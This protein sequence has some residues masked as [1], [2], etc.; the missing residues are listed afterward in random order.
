MTHTLTIDGWV[1]VSV[2]RLLGSHWA[3]ARKRKRFDRD[4][5]AAEALRQGIPGAAGRR[6]VSVAVTTP[7]RGGLPDPDNLLKSLLDA[8][9]RCGLLLDDSSGKMELGAVTVA[10]GERRRTVV[11]LEDCE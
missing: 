11:T 4:V 5:V 1:P 8:L 7:G 2:N 3:R 6:R 10:R 9:T